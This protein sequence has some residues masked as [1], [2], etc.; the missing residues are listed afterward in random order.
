MPDAPR[1]EVSGG[2]TLL[3]VKVVPGASRSGIVGAHG[4]RLRI[5]VA[6]PP[7][8]GKANEALCLLLAHALGLRARDVRVESGMTNPEKTLRIVGRGPDEVRRLW[9]A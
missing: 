4:D 5:R 3:W 6:A 2:D 7:E 9:T 8:A 1:C